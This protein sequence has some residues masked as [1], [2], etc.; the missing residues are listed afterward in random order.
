M[1]WSVWMNRKNSIGGALTYVKVGRC[2]TVQVSPAWQL[3]SKSKIT[4]LGLLK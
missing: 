4:V 2:R 3:F 1:F